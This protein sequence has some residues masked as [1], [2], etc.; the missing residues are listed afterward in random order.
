MAEKFSCRLG[1]ADWVRLLRFTGTH[2]GVLARC[3]A[4]GP[5][6]LGPELLRGGRP[7]HVER[8]RP[9]HFSAAIMVGT[10]IASIGTPRRRVLE[11]VPSR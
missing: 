11:H 3:R 7:R 4:D 8:G 6:A 10:S 2:H 9:A 1:A 5:H